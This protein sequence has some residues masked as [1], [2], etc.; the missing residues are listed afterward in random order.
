MNALGATRFAESLRAWGASWPEPS[1][2]LCVSAHREETPLSVTASEHPATVHDLTGFPPALYAL[3]YPAPGAPPVAGRTAA[4]LAAARIPVRLDSAAG[5]D[6]P[7]LEHYAPVVV[8]A[9]AGGG[10]PA[11]F[12][13]TGFEHASLSLRCVRWG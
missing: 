5:L 7:T 3:R 2:I 10:D 13:I 12:P 8:C 11:T 9:A 1:A 6:H 4:L